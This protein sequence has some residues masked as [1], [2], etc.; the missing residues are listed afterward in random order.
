M[1][2]SGRGAARLLVDVAAVPDAQHEHSE[3]VVLDVVDDVVVANAD[4]EFTFASG[5]LNGISIVRYA[6]SAVSSAAS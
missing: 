1:W 3:G 4:A 2:K 5:E 6:G